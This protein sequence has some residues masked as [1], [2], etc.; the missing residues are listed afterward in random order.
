M[1]YIDAFNHF[2]PE[3][4][5]RRAAGDAGRRQG[6]RQARARHSGAV[7][8]RPAPARRRACSTI[9]RRC[10]RSACRRWS[11]CGAPTSRPRWPR[12]G[13]DGLAEIVAKHPEPVRRLVGAAA[14][15]RAGGGREGSRARAQE[16]RQRHPDRHQRQ[17][18]AARRAAVLADLRGDRQVRQAD[19]AA[20]LAHAR[21]AGL[22]DREVFEIRDL[23]RARLALRD[24]R[25]AGAPRV[26]RHHG[27]LSGPQGHRA[28]SRRRHSV[29]RR[30]RRATA[31]I[32]SARAPRTR[33]TARCSRG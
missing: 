2:F 13:N 9:T 25:D 18:R 8:S 33:T 10:C 15:E 6:S 5:L 24:R 11:G 30:P 1:R 22:P 20:S 14:D 29:S 27:P 3:A 23:Q 19:P 16:R 4:L 26:L 12:I 31:S 28:P 7:R 17:R 21:D 32:S